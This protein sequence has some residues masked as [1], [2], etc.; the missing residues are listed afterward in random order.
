MPPEFY[1]GLLNNQ[2]MGFYSAATLVLDAKRHGVRV[3]PVNVAESDWLCTVGDDDTLRLG[4]CYVR[5]LQ[6]TDGHRIVAERL[7]GSF[8]SLADFQLRTKLPKPAQRTLAKIGAL[9]GLADHRREAQW[10]ME[11]FRHPMTSSPTSRRL[12]KAPLAPMNPGERPRRTTA[13]PA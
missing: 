10:K 7:R 8:E 11:V 12:S 1:A 2:P 4:L 3:R 13:A 5:G 6:T 9:N